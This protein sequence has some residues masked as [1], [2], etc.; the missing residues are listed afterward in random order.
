[1]MVESK[2]KQRLARLAAEIRRELKD[3]A[4]VKK[5]ALSAL[6]VFQK[7]QP[8]LLEV[9]GT[10]GI[11]HD[12]YNGMENVFGRIS[13]ELDGGIPAGENWHRVLLSNMAMQ[14]SD[15]RPQVIT[16]DTEQMLDEFLRF[17][18]LCRH[19]Y[20]HQLEWERIRELLE[21]VEV[22]YSSFENDL[23]AFMSFLETLAQSLKS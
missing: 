9:R 16:Q 2:E 11:L 14:V 15:I 23:T 13:D 5:E 3:I 4:K 19:G 8:K 18:H 7:K 22:A 1:M 10:A 12:F 20:G 6:E 17:R 21:K